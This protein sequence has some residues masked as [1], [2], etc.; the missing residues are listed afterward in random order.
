MERDEELS[1]LRAR[2]A[3]LERAQETA[4]AIARNHGLLAEENEVLK[5]RVAELERERRRS[6]EQHRQDLATFE[7]EVEALVAVAEARQGTKS[8]THHGYALPS[9]QPRK[10]GHCE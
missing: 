10:R 6:I 5:D 4:D 7:R 9:R 2:V 8:C 3:E 1:A